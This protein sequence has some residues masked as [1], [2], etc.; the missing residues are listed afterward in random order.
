MG[1]TDLNKDEDAK[2]DIALAGPMEHVV[3]RQCKACAGTGEVKT[4]YSDLRLYGLE[5]E[6]CHNC[7]GAGNMPHNAKI[8][9]P[10]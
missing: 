10:R 9:G 3:M 4:D 5:S 2:I 6:K 8:T 7:G 1:E